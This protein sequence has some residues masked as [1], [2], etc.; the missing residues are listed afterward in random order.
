MCFSSRTD[1]TVFNNRLNKS[2]WR[3]FILL[4]NDIDFCAFCTRS[5]RDW[6]NAGHKPHSKGVN[7]WVPD[8]LQWKLPTFIF[9]LSSSVQHV[10]NH[11]R[12]NAFYAIPRDPTAAP[13]PHPDSNPAA[14]SSVFRNERS[15]WTD[16][17]VAVI[18]V[19]VCCFYCNRNMIHTYIDSNECA[20]VAYFS[21]S[22]SAS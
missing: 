12:S 7:T 14:T 8:Q 22:S 11:M 1:I 10:L 6:F 20:I 13:H 5:R 4:P 19:N 16:R 3:L 17:E 2:Y 15:V 21:S 18:W 9:S